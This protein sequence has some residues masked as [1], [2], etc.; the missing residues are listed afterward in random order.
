M[1]TVKFLNGAKAPS[2]PFIVKDNDFLYESRDM[3]ITEIIDWY[4]RNDN[5]TNITFNRIDDRTMV[6]NISEQYKGGVKS[7]S[8][9]IGNNELKSIVNNYLYYHPDKKV[10]LNNKLI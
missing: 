5:T 6:I 2:S 9:T 10:L 8:I 3:I 7:K 4:Y 1:D